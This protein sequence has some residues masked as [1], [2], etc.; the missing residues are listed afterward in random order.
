MKK[1]CLMLFMSA[2]FYANEVDLEQDKEPEKVILCRL[3]GRLGNQLFQVAAAYSLAIDNDAFLSFPFIEKE[4]IWNIQE[5]W[6]EIFPF[7]ES[8]R[9]EGKFKEFCQNQ[10]YVYRPVTFSDKMKLSGYFQ[11]EKYFK[12][13]KEKIVSL[14][15]PN[16]N[17]KTSLKEKYSDLIRHPKT[18]GIH[19]RAYSQE[20]KTL[21][22]DFPFLELDYYKNCAA[23]FNDDVLFVIFSDKIQWAK[24][25]FKD[26]DRPHIFIEGN[27]QHEDFYL[28]SYCKHQILSSSTFGWWAAYLNSNPNKVV[29]AP[30]P[31]FNKTSSHSSK[32]VVPEDWIKVSY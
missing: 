31:W 15:Q 6:K 5:N 28:L 7:I 18:V 13:N 22:K 32:D 25:L 9:F 12:H 17:I 2:L 21:I 19:I 3:Q 26:F 30:D 4:K 16:E 29:I 27:T 20:C 23:Y 11:S 14:F 24:E 8:K 1:L 10:D